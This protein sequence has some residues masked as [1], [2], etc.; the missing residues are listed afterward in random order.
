[1]ELSPSWEADNCAAIRELPSILWN[2]EVHHR[3]HM[4]PPPV[5]ILIQIDPT[6]YKNKNTLYNVENIA[7][8]Y[9]DFSCVHAAWK[10]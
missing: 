5:P 4:S 8:K 3:V 1:M 2:P 10:I 7:V 6:N 9:L